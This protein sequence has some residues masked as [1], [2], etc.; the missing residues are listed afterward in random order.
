[1]VAKS[2]LLYDFMSLSFHSEVAGACMSLCSTVMLVSHSL[3]PSSDHVLD[4]SWHLQ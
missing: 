3:V 4:I 1:M 2:G